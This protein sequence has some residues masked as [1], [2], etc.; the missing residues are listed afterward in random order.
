MRCGSTLEQRRSKQRTRYG[1][2]QMIQILISL[3]SLDQSKSGTIW[4]EIW[5]E[6]SQGGFPERRWNDM[7]VA[8]F[9]SISSATLEL[10]NGKSSAEATFFDG[11]M[12]LGFELAG[13]DR[14]AV[15]MK[16]PLI[17]NP[18]TAT[19]SW[20]EWISTVSNS[21]MRISQEC[22][23]RG[24]ADQKDVRDLNQVLSSVQ[25]LLRPPQSRR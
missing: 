17:T 23:R 15:D 25:S 22:G 24:W 11:P 20:Q 2:R 10:S 13:P 4:G 8:V 1:D 18:R 12:Q 14:L 6:D 5:I 3:D 19:T 16:G 7:I 21:G 9:L